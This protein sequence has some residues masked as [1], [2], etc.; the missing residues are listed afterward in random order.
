[1]ADFPERIRALR[2]ERKLTQFQMSQVCGVQPRA[3]QSYEYGQG[4]PGVAGLLH[5]AD[6]FEV[7]LDYLMGRSDVREIQKTPEQ[8]EKE[9]NP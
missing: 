7:S 9:C 3:Y 2:K 8:I 5:L 6:F 4:Y 1:M